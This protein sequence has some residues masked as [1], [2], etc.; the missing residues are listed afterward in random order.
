VEFKFEVA[1]EGEFAEFGGVRVTETVEIG[2]VPEVIGGG[3]GRGY[4]SF[5]FI[6]V[7]KIGWI[8]DDRERGDYVSKRF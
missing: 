8:A 6:E 3:G 2:V 4:L 5:Q 1:I 7:Q